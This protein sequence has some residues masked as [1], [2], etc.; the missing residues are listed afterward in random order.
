MMRLLQ[1]ILLS[2]S[3]TK[4]SV[5]PALVFYITENAKARGAPRAFCFAVSLV[6]TAQKSKLRCAFV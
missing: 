4:P 6:Q 2:G 5:N 1:S 3:Q